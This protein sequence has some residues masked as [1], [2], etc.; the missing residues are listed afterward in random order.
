MILSSNTAR[1]SRIAASKEKI[2]EA[3]AIAVANKK[4]AVIG[5]LLDK[6]KLT[7]KDM[8]SICDHNPFRG[9]LLYVLTDKDAD[10]NVLHLFLDKGLIDIHCQSAFFHVNKNMLENATEHGREDIVSLLKMYASLKK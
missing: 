9:N 2:M 7:Q 5:T 3:L 1:L 8:G 4:I 10:I 6:N